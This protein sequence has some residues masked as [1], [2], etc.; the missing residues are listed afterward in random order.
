LGVAGD[1]SSAVT[2]VVSELVTN[3][4]VHAATTMRFQVSLEPGGGSARIEVHDGVVPGA[5]AER[6]GSPGA[7]GLLGAAGAGR[8]WG[9]PTGGRGLAMVGRLS[10][11]WGVRPDAEGKTVWAIVV[12]A[13]PGPGG[14]APRA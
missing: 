8:A 1:R 6:V 5:R 3:A 13:E 12:L 9:D 2:L 10:R 11:E 14:R 4:I 7:G